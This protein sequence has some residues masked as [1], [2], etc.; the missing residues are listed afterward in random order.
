MTQDLAARSLAGD[1]ARQALTRAAG[2]AFS[3]GNRVRLLKDAS[4]NYPAWLEAIARAQHHVHFENYIIHDDELGQRFAEALVERAQAGVQVRLIYDWWGCFNTA[5]RRFWAS[6]RDAGVE[7]RVYNPP[8]LDSPLSWLSRD[9][10]KTVSVDG[11]VGFVSGLCVGRMWVGDASRNVEPWR[12]TGVELRG[13]AVADLE[14][15]FATLWA[16]LGDPIAPAELI[17]TGAEVGGEVALRVVASVPQTAG[18]LPVSEL[19]AALAQQRLWLTDA[20]FSGTTRYLRA[21]CDAARAGVDVRLLLPGASDIPLMKPL[22]RAGYRGLLESGVRIFEWDGVMLH[23]KTAVADSIWSRIGSTNLNPASWFGNC[24]LDVVIDDTA[25][26][27]Q[28]EQQ[29]LDDLSRS[30]EVVLDAKRRVRAPRPKGHHGSA[31][32]TAA[33][34]L[35]VGSALGAGLIRYR[36]LEPTEGRLMLAAACVLAALAT[37][38]AFFPRF[39]SYGLTAVLGWLAA[40]F[41]YR[42]IRVMRRASRTGP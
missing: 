15:A 1:L 41:A 6:L 28:M 36:V 23:A 25:F 18:L 17:V 11:A 42:G 40:T 32:A 38:T 37:L 16:T 22:S 29:F 31:R 33:G 9:H 34:A 20:Y 8:H 4:E 10:R 21:L 39:A 5:S 26:A 27:Q 24:E 30:T 2:G 12:D 13:P 19:A 7:V 14:H 35:R 3:Q